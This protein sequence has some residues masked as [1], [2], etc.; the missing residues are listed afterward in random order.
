[1]NAGIVD[2]VWELG[3]LLRETLGR[4]F[5]TGASPITGWQQPNHS[6]NIVLG[7]FRET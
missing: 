7:K 3:E 6:R 2:H 4:W 5:D 1:M